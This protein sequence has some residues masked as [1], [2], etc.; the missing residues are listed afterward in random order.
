M[1]AR[2]LVLASVLDGI[3]RGR[4]SKVF[5]SH[6]YFAASAHVD[7]QNTSCFAM[8]VTQWVYTLRQAVLHVLK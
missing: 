2:C 5:L 8:R 4:A 3:A 7:N 6:G 1:T